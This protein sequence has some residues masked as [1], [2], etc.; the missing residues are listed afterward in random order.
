MRA[1]YKYYIIAKVSFSNAVAYRASVF[2]GLCFYTLFIYIFMSLWHAIYKEGSVNGYSVVQI[3]WYLI[4][5]ELVAFGCRTSI[6]SSM[7]DDVKSGSIAYLMGRPT[8]Y[9]FYQFANSIGS[10][11]LNLI[12]FG[13]LA[14]ILGFIFA[15]PLT[16]FAIYSLPFVLLSMILGIIINFFFLMMIGLTAFVI[17]DNF[18]IFLI[19][20]KFT[21]MLGVFL[22]IEFLPSWLQGIARNLPFSYVAWAPAK[23]FVSF[24]WSMFFNL[25]TRQIIWAAAVIWLTML[26]YQVGVRKLQANGG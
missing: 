23:L 7:N 18:A 1:L 15:G 22:P 16:T 25:I 20:Q 11:M 14:V 3:V 24:T 9:V 5:T 26:I 13:A 4:M 10:I 19:Y 21:F 17:E 8:H 12:C 2:S 6:Y